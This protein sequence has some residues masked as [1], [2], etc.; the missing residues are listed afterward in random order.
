MFKAGVEYF[1][2]QPQ[3]VSA[4]VIVIAARSAQLFDFVLQSVDFIFVFPTLG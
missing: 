3:S 4:L 2:A 1:D